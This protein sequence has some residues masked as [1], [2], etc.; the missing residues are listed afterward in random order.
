MTEMAC[1]DDLMA[2]EAAYLA[3]LPSVT[4]ASRA[5]DSL[6]LS[7]PQVELHFARVQPVPNADLAG[8]LWTLDSLISGEVVASVIGD[9]PT[10]QLKANGTLAA[11]TGCRD[12]TGHYTVSGNQVKVTLDP[13]DAIACAN[14]LGAQDSHVLKVI[15]ALDGFSV[16]IQ[17][18]S[19]TLTA[20]NLGLGYRVVAT[21]S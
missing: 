2:A 11:S 7:G 12:L 15:G 21:G 5:G 3:A 8:P 10:L 17:G 19:M 20:G 14:P 4:T 1:Q 9:A 13:Y 16:T 18:N 6:V